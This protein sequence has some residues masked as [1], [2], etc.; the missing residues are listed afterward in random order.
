MKTTCHGGGGD[1]STGLSDYQNL[2]QHKKLGWDWD[3]RLSRQANMSAMIP[4]LNT[5]G[6]TTSRY[7]YP[8]RGSEWSGLGGSHGCPGRLWDRFL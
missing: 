6:K 5:T 1:F 2:I 4:K 3:K 8:V 7:L